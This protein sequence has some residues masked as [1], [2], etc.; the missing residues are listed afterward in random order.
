VPGAANCFGSVSAYRASLAYL[1]PN[2]VS[3]FLLIFV[4]TVLFLIHH[5]LFTAMRFVLLAALL[6]LA[7]CGDDVERQDSYGT[8]RARSSRYEYGS[9]VGGKGGISLWGDHDD[10]RKGAVSGISVNAFLWRAALDTLAFMPIASADPFGGTIITDWYAPP[11]SP[12]ERVK[13]NV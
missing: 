12:N 2:T 5:S 7:A 9:V 4:L 11:S 8:D 6:L 3:Q 13:V 10:A 1:N